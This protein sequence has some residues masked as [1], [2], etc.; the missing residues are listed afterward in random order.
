MPLTDAM[1]PHLGGSA[2]P[3]DEL[4][5]VPFEDSVRA[6]GQDSNSDSDAESD[7]RK[8]DDFDA[9]LP[10]HPLGI[11]PLGNRYL[12]QGTDAKDATGLFQTLPDELVMLLAETLDMDSLRALGSTCRFFYAACTYDELWKA[13]ALE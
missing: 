12:D 7:G 1:A 8:D 6:I 11:K 4:Q 10:P 9:P 13:L 2:A 3:L 5:T